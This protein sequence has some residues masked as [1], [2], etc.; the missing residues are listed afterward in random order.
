MLTSS[1][2]QNYLTEAP[3]L[4]LWATLCMHL[5]AHTWECMTAMPSFPL[6]L[7]YNVCLF[8]LLKL[9]R[10]HT[11]STPAHRQDYTVACLNYTLQTMMPL[12]GWP[13][14]APNAYDNNNN[15]NWKSFCLL[16]V[17]WVVLTKLYPPLV[18]TVSL[19]NNLY[20]VFQKKWRQNRNYNNCNKSYQN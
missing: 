1:I 14:M 10:C 18:F 6:M 12:P 7:L 13:V 20:S 8:F 4:T 2:Q 15:W 5:Q 16:T 19:Q 3:W 17:L 9:K 11:L